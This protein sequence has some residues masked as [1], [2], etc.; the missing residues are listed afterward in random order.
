MGYNFDAFVYNARIGFRKAIIDSAGLNDESGENKTDIT[1]DHLQIKSALPAIG[2]VDGMA[3]TLG[4]AASTQAAAT[5]AAGKIVAYAADGGTVASSS[6][7]VMSAPHTP[8]SPVPCT[9]QAP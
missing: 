9:S 3:V 7:Q 2:A 6:I 1:I 4:I 5:E 8:E